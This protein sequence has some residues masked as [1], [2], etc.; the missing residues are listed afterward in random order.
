MLIT[1]TPRLKIFQLIY[2]YLVTALA[3]VGTVA[4]DDEDQSCSQDK[5]CT[6]GQVCEAGSCQAIPCNGIGECPGTGR[7][8]L[9]D[10]NTCSP[11]ECGDLVDSVELMCASGLTCN[12]DGPYRFS[13]SSPTGPTQ[14]NSEADCVGA[15][16]GASCCSGLC[17]MTCDPPLT[18]P[19]MMMGGDVPPVDMGLQPI[20]ADLCTPCS[21]DNACSPLG[22]GAKCTPIG[23][24]SFCTSA[25]SGGSD[26]PS[27]FTC[28]TSLSQCVPTSFECV[29]CQQTPCAAGEFCDLSTGECGPPQGLCGGCSDDEGCAGTNVCK[30]V[31]GNALC[32][33]ACD[34]GCPMGTTCTDGGCIPD[35][36]QCD[37]CA[38]SC[39]GD[40][41]FCVAEE[42]R[43]AECGSN[44]D[45]ADGLRCDLMTHT[46]TE[47]LPAG[48]CITD[49]DCQGGVCFTGSCVECFQDSDCP[50][51]NTCDTNSFTCQY[52]PCSGVEC[53]RGSTCDAATGRCAPGCTSNQ[54]CVL[55][56]VMECNPAT[57][58][59]YYTD[60]TCDLAGDAVCAPGGQ[61]MPNPLAAFDPTL[62]SVCSCAKEDPMD[63]LSA[64]RIACHPGQSCNDLGAL[65]ML[66]LSALGIE[67]DATC[68]A[69]IF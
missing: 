65:L 6:R 4:C 17:A 53:Q 37:A 41:P 34:A 19:D 59:C 56:D 68:G 69:G 5:S 63:P 42:S 20:E 62:P 57:G 32:V 11:K 23:S 30:T 10:L 45:C 60:G 3:F 18:Q 40:T 54:D 48:M 55:P 15:A 27:G 50:A 12:T 24:G 13:C 1:R 16:E 39:G 64:D 28:L 7:T 66:D 2:V 8:C 47:G 51:R 58:Q 35:S 9:A 31:S 61:C 14:C 38:G 21:G 22:E 43:C 36:G 44:S 46:C 33:Q 52:S 29:A 25:C 49:A 67:F 26:C